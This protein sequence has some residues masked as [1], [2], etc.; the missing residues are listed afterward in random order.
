VMLALPTLCCNR[1]ASCWRR[2]RVCAIIHFVC[3]CAGHGVVQSI[4]CHR[5]CRRPVCTRHV[6]CRSNA[7]PCCVQVQYSGLTPL[8]TSL[9]NK[10]I[11]PFLAAG[12]N[13]RSLAKPIL[14]RCVL[15]AVHHRLL[16]RKL[17]PSAS[18]SP[19]N[20]SSTVASGLLCPQCIA[21]NLIEA[22]SLCAQH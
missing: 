16:T 17:T 4:S 22:A 11:Q 3:E 20:F 8:G 18:P 19:S 21:L 7:F 2:P 15:A 13:S 9:N 14:V 6:C 1:R 5:L 10:V 12:I